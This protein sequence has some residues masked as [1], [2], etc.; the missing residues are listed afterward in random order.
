MSILIGTPMYGGQ[1]TAEYFESCL[2]LKEDL[3]TVGV[4]HDWAILTNES[5]IT[6]ARNTIAD[7]FLKTDFEALLFIDADIRFG[8]EDVAKLWNLDV[9]IASGAYSL[10][11]NSGRLSCWLDN[12]TQLTVGSMLKHKE[13]IEVY[14]AATGFMMIKREVFEA[15]SG[16]VPYYLE[17][18]AK[19]DYFQTLVQ[20]ETLLSEDYLFCQMARETD[21]KIIV[22]PSIKLGHVGKTE[23]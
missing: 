13:P 4:E 6:R 16:L 2:N 19:N 15:L 14:C 1:C 3:T 23:Y 7:M 18:G 8:T 10:K 22:G 5:L 11:D 9:P 20:D 21:Y 12:E 17:D